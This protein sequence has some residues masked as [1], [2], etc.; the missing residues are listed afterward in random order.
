[1]LTETGDGVLE[2]VSVPADVVVQP[3]SVGVVP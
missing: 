2:A 1:M 3:V